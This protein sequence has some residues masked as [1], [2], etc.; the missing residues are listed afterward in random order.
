[1][2]GQ[3]EW[4]KPSKCLDPR[5]VVIESAMA[6]K[7]ES[8]WEG[9]KSTRYRVKCKENIVLDATGM[10]INRMIDAGAKDGDTMTFKS[11][12]TENNRQDYKIAIVNS[13][14]SGEHNQGS[15]Y[16]ATNSNT[17]SPIDSLTAIVNSNKKRIEALER[18]LESQNSDE[19]ENLPF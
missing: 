19:I 7:F 9:K 16:V 10:F 13:V 18:K 12:K 8:E 2:S 17:N 15:G 1:M 6:E 3:T 5:T 11:F 14:K 4:L